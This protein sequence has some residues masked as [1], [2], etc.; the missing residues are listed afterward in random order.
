MSAANPLERFRGEKYLSLET[1][2][3]NGTPIAT[4]LWFSE[5][6]GVLYVYSLANAGKVKRARNN[7]KARIA[8]CDIRGK[9]RPGAEWISVTAS[10]IDGEEAQRGHQLLT[11]KYGW[12]KR[13][14]DIYSGI[15]RRQRVAITLSVN[16]VP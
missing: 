14:G 5:G 3:K 11:K 13:F 6:D 7:P 8:P 4:P 1:Y 12:L 16:L 10:L 2:R 15:L 9:V